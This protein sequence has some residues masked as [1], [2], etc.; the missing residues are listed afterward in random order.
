MKTKLFFVYGTLKRGGTLASGF[1]SSR[2]SSEKATIHN[3]NLYQLGWFPGIVPG[4][5]QVIGELHE[6]KDPDEVV[7]AMDMMEGYDGTENSLFTRELAE[8]ITSTGKKIEAIVYVF[9]KGKKE[10]FGNLIK[11]GIW[12]ITTK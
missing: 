6:Y 3:M 2:I 4:D 11:S 12:D 9:N 5:G 10:V 1:D 7:Q 8:V